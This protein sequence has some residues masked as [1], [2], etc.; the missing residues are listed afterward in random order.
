MT[1]GY[2]DDSDASETTVLPK[3]A[4]VP[5]DLEGTVEMDR[6]TLMRRIR[7]ETG[8]EVEDSDPEDRA[9]TVQ[10]PSIDASTAPSRSTAGLPADDATRNFDVPDSVMRS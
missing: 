6:K 8:Q 4:D 10:L 3:D 9:A 1:D 7:E 2:D 5:V